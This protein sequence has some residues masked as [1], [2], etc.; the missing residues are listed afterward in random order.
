MNSLERPV[1]GQAPSF[2]PVCTVV[3]PPHPLWRR[4]AAKDRIRLFNV[5]V[6]DIRI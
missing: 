6:S 2:R 4:I 1:G 3:A 5:I